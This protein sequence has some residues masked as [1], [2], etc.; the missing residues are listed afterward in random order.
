M[1]ARLANAPL[2]QWNHETDCMRNMYVWISPQGWGQGWG[3]GVCRV[4]VLVRVR[5]KVRFGVLLKFLP[6]APPHTETK[7]ATKRF[8]KKGS[9]TSQIV[10]L[11]WSWPVLAGLG[12]S[13]WSW[14]L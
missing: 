12:C 10:A 13:G 1:R 14:L 3:V 8:Q 6:I 4:K 9:R 11:G 7:G 5:V 2:G